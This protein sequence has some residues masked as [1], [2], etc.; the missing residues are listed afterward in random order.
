MA[1]HDSGESG[2][3]RPSKGPPTSEKPYISYILYRIP[4]GGWWICPSYFPGDFCWVGISVLSK[5]LFRRKLQELHAKI[6]LFFIATLEVHSVKLTAK[7]SRV[8]KSSWG[9]CLPNI[10][11]VVMVIPLYPLRKSHNCNNLGGGFNPIEI[12][13]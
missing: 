3:S 1:Y 2:R 11:G 13:E 12:Y 5:D 6:G 10:K 7:A 4:K 9:K 8:G